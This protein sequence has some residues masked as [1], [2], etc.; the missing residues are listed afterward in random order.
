[1]VKDSSDRVNRVASSVFALRVKVLLP[2][3]GVAW[4]QFRP[5]QQMFS[6]DCRQTTLFQSLLCHVRSGR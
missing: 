3:Q 6:S 2:R 4:V 5:A 1:M